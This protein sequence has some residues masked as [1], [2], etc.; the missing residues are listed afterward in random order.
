MAAKNKI[1]QK[2]LSKLNDLP[3]RIKISFEKIFEFWDEWAE[4]ESHINH[5]QAKKV[6]ESIEHAPILR[7]RFSDLSL[8]SKYKMEI[9]AILSCIFP[10]ALTDNE[11][12]AAS[13][14]FL[15]VFFNPT[16]RLKGIL[17]RAGEDFELMIRDFELA[18]I[19]KVVGSIYLKAVYGVDT[20]YKQRIFFDIPDK[21]TNTVKQYRAFFNA[22]FSEF[23]ENEKTIKLNQHQIQLLID[24]Y[25]DLSLWK[26]LVPP[27]SFDFIGVALITIFDVTTDQ[28]LSALKDKLLR[29]DVLHSLESVKKL[30]KNVGNFLG[31]PEIHLGMAAYDHEA[32]K[33][34]SLGATNWSSILL[35]DQTELDRRDGFCQHAIDLLFKKDEKYIVSNITEEIANQSCTN[36]VF[37]DQ[38]V[39]SVIIAPLSYGKQVLGFL[40]LSSKKE[41]V[42][43]SIVG[44]QLDEL[45][46]LFTVAMKRTLDEHETSIEAIVQDQFT[47]IHSS[48]SWKFFNAAEK[49]LTAKRHGYSIEPDPIIF[50]DVIPIF[51]QFDIRGSSDAR[52]EAIQSDLIEQLLLAE[53]VFIVAIKTNDLPI[54]KH[55]LHRLKLFRKDLK[56]QIHTGDEIKILEFMKEEIY[57][58][59]KF[60][61]Q[62]NTDLKN[63]ITK[64]ESAVDQQLQVVYKQRK[65][66]EET[67]TILNEK[68]SDYLDKKE[69]EAQE[70]F[71]HYFEKYKTDGIEY[72][73][74]VG[75]SLMQARDYHPIHLHNLR[76]WQLIITVEIERLVLN[77]KDSLA[78]NLEIASLILV[79]NSPLA[80]K[81]RMD[82]KQFDV[83]GAYNIRYEIMKKRI[84]K[85][86]IKGTK[87]RLTQPRKISIVYSQDAEAEEYRGYLQYLHAK[88]YVG[89]T[90]EDVHLQDLQGAT[91]LKALRVDVMYINTEDSEIKELIKNASIV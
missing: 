8:I 87:E 53:E 73:I 43:N 35:K 85:A 10:E 62:E 67:V 65:A 86:C 59:F 14:P 60:L 77:L 64:Y 32:K 80:I 25:D 71:P 49:I 33:I 36:K 68:M 20:N 42:L 48:V 31:L 84:D 51:G 22:D 78:V 19:Y 88:N 45:I 24:N 28:A 2:K 55:L 1:L 89:E 27:Q 37:F 54:Y 82:E 56:E 3:F 26:K 29:K 9:E 75:Q 5:L 13:L 39:K 66:Y 58:V 63:V 30:E 16:R 52:N 18:D 70:M 47:S 57:P 38:N 81:F 79:D 74:Y 34:K 15:P 76:L 40:E 91:G 83:D 90:I 61:N 72:N 69:A 21:A 46:P 4:N 50:N 12:K 6:L 23:K 11:I 44:E 41:G 17:E 7:T